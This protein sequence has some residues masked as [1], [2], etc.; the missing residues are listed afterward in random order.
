MQRRAVVF[1]TV[2]DA[3]LGNA[4][5]DGMMKPLTSDE[6]ETVKAEL[7]RM[8]EENARLGVRTV[9][10]RKDFKRKMKRLKSHYP[11][12][13]KLTKPEEVLLVGWVL[14]CLTIQACYK[15]LAAINR[16]A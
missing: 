4:I 13:R 16:E 10:D 12:V 5:V 9:R 1:R 14:F 6:L 15:K 8:K 2:G 3:E 7:E 11:P